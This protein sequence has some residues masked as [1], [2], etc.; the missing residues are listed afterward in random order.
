MEPQGGLTLNNL[1]SSLN[2]IGWSLKKNTGDMSLTILFASS[3]S[4]P[5]PSVSPSPGR[6]PPQAPSPGRCPPR[7]PSTSR[8]PSRA[9]SVSPSHGRCPPRAPS[10]SRCPPRAP[11][12]DALSLSLSRCPSELSP[13]SLC[14]LSP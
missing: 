4:W 8:C 2:V 11:S 3:L 9:P 13:C 12:T 5:V 6:C 10:T 14:K 1:L 7:A